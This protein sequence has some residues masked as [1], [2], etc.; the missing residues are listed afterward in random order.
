MCVS[1][2]GSDIHSGLNSFQLVAYTAV[3]RTTSL[4]INVYLLG[5]WWCMCVC[6]GVLPSVLPS[7]EWHVGCTQF[8]ARACHREEAVPPWITWLSMWGQRRLGSYANT[9]GL[10][11]AS[12]PAHELLHARDNARKRTHTSKA[13]TPCLH[14]EKIGMPFTLWDGKR[15]TFQLA[16]QAKSTTVNTV[17][18]CVCAGGGGGGGGSWMG[19]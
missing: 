1:G 18:V 2:P 17:R 12:T 3:G 5:G 14:A 16:A 6:G 9:P 4:N 15:N 19:P 10:G 7:I 8:S 11:P 13:H